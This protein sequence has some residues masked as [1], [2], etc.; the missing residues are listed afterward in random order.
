MAQDIYD[1]LFDTLYVKQQI[2]SL[3]FGDE[4]LGTVLH[5]KIILKK[6]A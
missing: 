2:K 5:E 1:I 6:N 3:R 4:E